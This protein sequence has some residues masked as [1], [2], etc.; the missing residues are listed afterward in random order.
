MTSSTTDTTQLDAVLEI[1][2]EAL[3]QIVALRDE[4]NIEGLSLGIRIAGV[5]PNG[6]TYETAFVRPED[7]LATDHVEEHG[8]LRVAISA[9]L[10]RQPAGE[11]ARRLLRPQCPRP[12]VA[13]PQP[14]VPGGWRGARDPR[15]RAVR[16]RRGAGGAAARPGDQ[17]GH[18]RPRRVR[19]AGVGRGRHRLPPARRRLPG[20]RDGGDDP[21]SRHRDAP[22]SRTSPRSP[23]SSTSP[24]TPPARTPSTNS[25]GAWFPLPRSGRGAAVRRRGGLLSVAI[26]PT[27][28]ALAISTPRPTPDASRRKSAAQ[29]QPIS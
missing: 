19:Q 29:L 5:T 2:E 10:G 17:P 22:S 9:R 12:G 20:L 27:R 25:P 28:S 1:T 23:R 8:G 13:Q 16:H 24:T 7:V 3:G 6:F 14:A 11:R 26:V 21:A 4:E 18:R 15:H